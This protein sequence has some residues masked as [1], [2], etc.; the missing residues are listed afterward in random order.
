MV[1][2]TLIIHYI[3]INS[4]VR[5]VIMQYH[6]LNMIKLEYLLEHLFKLIFKFLYQS[7]IQNNSRNYSLRHQTSKSIQNSAYYPLHILKT[8]YIFKLK[9]LMMVSFFSKIFNCLSKMLDLML[10]LFYLDAP[11]L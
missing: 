2:H 6:Y 10:L 11:I 7:I 1:L 9:D 4:S 8:S 5:Y 3:R